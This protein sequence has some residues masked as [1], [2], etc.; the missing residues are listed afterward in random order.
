MPNAPNAWW[1]NRWKTLTHQRST[2]KPR[3]LGIEVGKDTERA[4]LIDRCIALGATF[5]TEKRALAKHGV[6]G[7]GGRRIVAFAKSKFAK[8]D[9]KAMAT[10]RPITRPRR[11]KKR[12]RRGPKKSWKSGFQTSRPQGRK[13]CRTGS[14][15][16]S[17]QVARP[18]GRGFA[19]L[20]RFPQ[21]LAGR[22]ARL[23]QLRPRMGRSFAAE[24]LDPMGQAGRHR[25]K[26]I[27]PWKHAGRING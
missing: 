9:R 13:S 23:W 4:A 15:R 7:V 17:G 8:M 16:R 10:T 6:Q 14:A 2:A 25:H 22:G 19:S 24:S 21:A 26:G 12:P 11:P 5:K 3:R 18:G 27:S 20:C 1:P